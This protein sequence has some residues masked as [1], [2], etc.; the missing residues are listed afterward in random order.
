MAPIT[1]VSEAQFLEVVECEALG[2]GK[3]M[4]S[5]PTEGYSYGANHVSVFVWVSARNT[6][7]SINSYN[8]NQAIVKP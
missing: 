5:R 4:V 3:W 1:P 2:N 7:I 8:G 6:S